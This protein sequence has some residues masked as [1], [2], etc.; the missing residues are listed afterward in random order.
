MNMLSRVS[1]GD[2][3]L[4]LQSQELLALHRRLLN[5]EFDS[6]EVFR[7]LLIKTLE[8]FSGHCRAMQIGPL[9]IRCA[10]YLFCA[11]FDEAVMSFSGL[12][13]ARY[14]QKQTL[15]SE[16]FNETVGG[17]T[18]FK[19]KDFCLSN[20][21]GLFDILCLVYLCL[22][23]GFQGRHA[24]IA[25]S[26]NTLEKQKQECWHWLSQSSQ[27]DSK[28]ISVV[29]IPVRSIEVNLGKKLFC[30]VVISSFIFLLMSYIVLSIFLSDQA[31]HVANL[32]S[33]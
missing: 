16:L 19:I 5:L 22:C 21:P 6:L 30:S 25:S 20:L 29:N 12:D 14:W 1:C 28:P 2:D 24:L 15:L 13:G 10:Q 33:L 9:N 4:L 32:V 11:L 27:V 23:L 8:S 3:R 17:E 18:F 31:G 26:E 7:G